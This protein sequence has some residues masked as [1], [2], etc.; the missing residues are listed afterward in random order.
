MAAQ[1]KI[2]QH[3]RLRFTKLLTIGGTT[4]WDTLDLPTIVPQSDDIHYTVMDSDRIELLA[5]KF[6]GDSVLWWV[7][8]EANGLELVPTALY[9]SQVLTIPSPRYVLQQLFQTSQNG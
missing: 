3:S 7:I 4:F 6:Y 5:Y 1:I 9:S 2:R 8:A